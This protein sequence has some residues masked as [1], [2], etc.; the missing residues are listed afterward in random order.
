[1]AHQLQIGTCDDCHKRFEY[2]LIH[3]GPSNSSYAYC[4]QCG[5]TALLDVAEARFPVELLK[6]SAYKVIAAGVEKHL[7]HCDC[8]GK[9]SRE[10]VPR[11]PHCRQPLSAV[12]AA[13]Y[14]EQQPPS[15]SHDWR[16]Q[17]NWTGN[18]CIIV[19]GRQIRNNFK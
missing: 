19:E 2:T 1:M 15:M 6:E 7:R 18:Y 17:K 13:D 9:F 11:C 8:G 16:W 12:R 4:D 14:I 3:N 5:K 10:G